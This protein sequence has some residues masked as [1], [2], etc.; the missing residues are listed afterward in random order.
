M[1]LRCR[2]KGVGKTDDIKEMVRMRAITGYIFTF[3]K[4]SLY[5]YRSII[6]LA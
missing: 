6:K 5:L 1:F 2:A 4:A 3:E